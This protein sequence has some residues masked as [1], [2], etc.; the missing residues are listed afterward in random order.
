MKKWIFLIT[1]IL[2]SVS[3]FS[4]EFVQNGSSME[5]TIKAG[6]TVKIGILSSFGYEPS[7]WD[8]VAVKNPQQFNLLVFR[9]IGLPNETIRLEEDGVYINDEK[10]KLPEKLIESGVHYLPASAVI[11]RKKY[12]NNVYT[13]DEEEYF[14]LGDNTVNANDSRFELGIIHRSL[15]LNKVEGD[16]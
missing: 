15:I 1:A 4:R 14:L 12:S 13:T 8:V 3:A 2:F 11:K 7:R 6:K 9:V 5:P 16:L 10:V